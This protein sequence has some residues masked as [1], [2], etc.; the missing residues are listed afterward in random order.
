MQLSSLAAEVS[1]YPIFNGFDLE[2][3]Q[4]ILGLSELKEVAPGDILIHP[5]RANDTFYL[6]VKGE[7]RVILENEGAEISVPIHPGECL[8]EMS[9][10]MERQT[11]A[12]A[13]GH[14]PSLVLCISEN[15]LWDE[16]LMTRK[17]IRNL[18]FLMASRLRRTNQALFK[19]IEEQL[20]YK[21]IEKEMETAGKIQSSIVPDGS[22]LLDA[23][24]AIDAY[25]MTNQAREVGGDFFDAMLLDD[26]HIYF[27]IGDVSG[28]GTPAALF[29][30]RT[31][32]S[33]RM[34]ITSKSRFEDVIPAVNKMLAKK[35]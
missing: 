2:Q 32:T 18:M 16:I 33:L 31:F 19:E 3:I 23:C 13:I 34:L 20:K 11:S 6:L 5:G 1:K 10:V 9:I 35:K 14:Q 21:A 26:E 17:G 22:K 29:M 4:E 24:S 7:L 8:G 25:A 15:V 30:M 27:A 28:K 12:Q